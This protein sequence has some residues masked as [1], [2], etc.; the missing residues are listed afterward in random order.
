MLCEDVLAGDLI[1][2]LIFSLNIL[3]KIKQPIN[4]VCAQMEKEVSDAFFFL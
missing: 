4:R 1:I 2:L 3:K